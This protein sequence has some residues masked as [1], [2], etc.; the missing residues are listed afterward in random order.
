MSVF[1]NIQV[2]SIYATQTRWTKRNEVINDSNA[3][4]T[5]SHP[6]PF[7]LDDGEL[8]AGFSTDEDTTK[9]S[10]KLVRSTDG[11]NT[12]GSKVTIASTTNDIF[13]GSFAQ[14]SA[15]NLVCVY[16]DG[17]GV[18]AKRSS[19]RGQTWGS[20][21]IIAP[22]GGGADP[23]PSVVNLGNNT[24]MVAY[25]YFN[26]IMT[27]KSTDGG[28]TWS[29]A[30][31]VASNSSVPYNSPSIVRMPSG[32]LVLAYSSGTGDVQFPQNYIIRSVNSGATWSTPTVAKAA[33]QYSFNDPNLAVLN[34][35]DLVM[36]LVN[37]TEADAVRYDSF[38]LSHDEGQTWSCESFIYGDSDPHRLNGVQLRNGSMLLMCASKDGGDNEYHITSLAP[39]ANWPT[40]Q[41]TAP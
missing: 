30:T 1:D 34:N 11:G 32:D 20:A 9:Y 33:A 36:W 41:C 16:G 5:F 7:E 17:D 18:A 21:I 6:Q 14:T 15:T 31:T 28:A 13:E 22:P 2:Q 25:R 27:R 19:D 26:K 29:I 39:P 3:A 12:W 24:L 37:G 8:I 35:G 38:I 10:Y 4:H 40:S 23:H